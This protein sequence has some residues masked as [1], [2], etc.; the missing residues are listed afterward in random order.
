MIGGGEVD[1][2]Y[3]PVG[4]EEEG[5]VRRAG[6]MGEEREKVNGELERERRVEG[7]IV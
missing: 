3:W 4:D 7:R 2:L 5:E 1:V 6:E